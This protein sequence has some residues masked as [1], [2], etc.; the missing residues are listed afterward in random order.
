MKI[1]QICNFSAGISGVTTRVFED[2]KEFIKEGHKVFVFSSDQQENGEKAISNQEI[3]E[4]IDITRFPVKFKTGYA[5]WFDFT[6]EALDLKPDVII[7]HGLRKPYL[8]QA[9]KISKK[10]G[11]KCFLVTHAPFV[12]E[13]L[14][15]TRLNFAIWFYDKFKGRKIMNSFDKVIAICK[16]E[17]EELLRLGCDGERIVYIPNSLS[18]E[19]F[20]KED[21]K[22]KWFSTE[23]KILFMGRMHPV[24]EIETLI[25]AFKESNMKDYSLEIVSSLTGEYYELLL[26]LKND[27]IVFTDA[28]STTKEKIS[29]LDSAEIFVLPSK[30]ESLPFGIIEAMARGKIVIATKTKGALE[31]I[32]S[33]RNGFLFDVGDKEGLKVLLNNLLE[34]SDE[35]KNKMKERAMKTSKEFKVSNTTAKWEDLLK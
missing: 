16:W 6:K 30:K 5:L 14:R 34:I 4:E 21:Y 3:K 23:K 11:I 24:K 33:K 12:D 32:K 35:S 15:S 10:L 18:E 7:C 20:I 29:K 17:K 28:I 25:E 31:L 26:K 19:F 27:R 13:E 1:L 8:Q 2:S 9:I 22:E